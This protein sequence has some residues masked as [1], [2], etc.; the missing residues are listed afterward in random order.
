VIR[1]YRKLPPSSQLPQSLIRLAAAALPKPAQ[2]PDWPMGLAST[3][4]FSS[5]GLRLLAPLRSI[6][7]PDP[8][9]PL[10][11]ADFRLRSGDTAWSCS[12]VAMGSISIVR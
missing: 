5:T 6:Q 9:S 11:Y 8:N 2:A 3:A 7:R 10:G 12:P 4:I 1:E